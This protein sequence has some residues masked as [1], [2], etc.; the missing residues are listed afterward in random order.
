MCSLEARKSLSNVF[1]SPLSSAFLND[2]HCISS[3]IRAILNDGIVLPKINHLCMTSSSSFCFNEKFLLSMS[4]DMES[5]LFD[6]QIILPNDFRISSYL[7]CLEIDTITRH[8]FNFEMKF[9][10]ESR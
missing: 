9:N 6:R 8:S 1:L 4:T 5:S 7:V 10:M 3:C 2:F